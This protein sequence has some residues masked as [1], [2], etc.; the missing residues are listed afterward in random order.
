[1]MRKKISFCLISDSGAPVKQ[2]SASRV[3][4]RIFSLFLIAIFIVLAFF[5][6]DYYTLKHR[7]LNN[8]MLRLKL[9][10]Q[11]EEINTQRRQIQKF[12]NE[13]NTLK[14][15]LVKLKDAEKKIRVIANLDKEG[16]RDGVFGVGGSLPEDIDTGIDVAEKHNSLL[17]EMHEQVEQLDVAAK[18][19]GED[20][21]SLLKHLE[22]QQSILVCTP[23]IRPTE[24]WITSKFGYRKSPF[25]GRREFHKGLDIATRKK[26]PVFATANGVVTFAGKKGYLGNIIVIDHGF[27]MVTR[28]AHLYKALKKRGD[29]V[30]RGDKIALVGGSGRTTG[31]HL[32]YEVHLNGLPVNPQKY[33]L[34]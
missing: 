33:I 17:R 31:P 5:G 9:S 28:Y 21:S 18:S 29:K 14:S 15:K 1:M 2:L 34:N 11:L 7:S 8:L 6:Y 30:K 13:I 32:H 20:F 26:T 12:A 25:T 4:L 22:E 23:A 27:G 24:G 19:Q 3:I 16:S 10:S